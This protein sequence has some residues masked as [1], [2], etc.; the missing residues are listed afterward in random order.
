MAGFFP[1]MMFGLPAA[2]L[3]MYHS[4]LPERRAAVGGLLGSIALTSILTGVTEP[5]EFTFMFLA[6][7]LYAVHA[8]LT[9]VAFI[10]M[11][12]LHVRLGFGFSAGLID[13]LLNFSRATRPLWLLPVGVGYFALYYGLFRFVIVR[14]DM[15]TPGRAGGD[16]L[17]APAAT[18]SPVARATAWIAALGGGANLRSVDACTTRLRL[19]VADQSAVDSDALRRLGAR[20]VVRPSPEALQVVVGTTADQLAGEIRAALQSGVS[21]A[22]AAPPSPQVSAAAPPLAD[23]TVIE[24]SSRRGSPSGAAAVLSAIGGHSNVRSVG[25][26]AS[27]VRIGIGDSSLLDRAAL[28]ALGLRGIA[29]PHPDC[30]HLIVGP[31]APALAAALRELLGS[32]AF[33]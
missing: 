1:V 6:P 4:A 27:R 15:K 29:L 9:G 19:R 8:L 5:I 3:A 12:A 21:A 24:Q 14:F 11:N 33:A 26:C 18:A 17:A 7:A 22:P 28:A 30:V 20:G 13:Y 23:R 2:C 25:T 10:V 31:E 16:T 32:P